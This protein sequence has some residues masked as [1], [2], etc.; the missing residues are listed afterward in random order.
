MC[1]RGYTNSGIPMVLKN[2][3]TPVSKGLVG[4]TANPDGLEVFEGFT[5]AST[6]EKLPDAGSPRTD[7]E[8]RFVP[9]LSTIG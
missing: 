4:F 6:W 1:K 5:L 2:K 7:D 8:F 9:V 3:N